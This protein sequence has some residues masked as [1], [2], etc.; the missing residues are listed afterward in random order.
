MGKEILIW[1]KFEFVVFGF[2]GY[3]KKEFLRE[4]DRFVRVKVVE[5]FVGVRRE[6]ERVL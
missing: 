4:D 3:K 2:Y 6:F 5:I 1:E